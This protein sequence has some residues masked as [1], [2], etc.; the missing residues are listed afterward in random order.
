MRAEAAFTLMHA[1]TGSGIGSVAGGRW[2][3]T[4]HRA[5][6][7]G[8]M[9]VLLWGE[10]AMAGGPRY[11]AGSS[12]FDAAVAGQPVVWANGQVRYFTDPG[13]LSA[14]VN[15]SQAN[16]MV[17]QAAAVWNGVTTAAVSIQRGGSLAESVDAVL[18][19]GATAVDLPADLQPG[20]TATPVGVVFD[21]NG[22]VI[23]ALYGS[24]ASS[25]LACQSNG[26]MTVVDN[27]STSGNLLHALIIVN[28]LCGT[29]ATQIANLQYQLVR[30]FGRVLGLDWSQANEA[31]FATNR[32]TDDG[33]AGWPVMHP[34]ERLCN[35]S[36]GTCMPN[37][38][39]F[40]DGRRGGAESRVPGDG[41]EHRE[42][43]RKG[44]DG[45]GDDFCAGHGGVCAR[46]GNAG[47]KH[48]AATAGEWCAGCAVYGDGG[49]RGLF[50]GE[51]GEC[52][53][54]RDGGGALWE[55]RCESGR[56]FRFERSAAAA[57]CVQRGL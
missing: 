48:R 9:A 33:L 38:L 23:D 39:Q 27:F 42:L 31:M 12:F 7:A 57:W 45:V 19:A 15:N 24:G 43:F 52:H 51:R 28:G 5:W 40:A 16:A 54:R 8:A 49:E 11:V 50:S 30:G 1:M 46:T 13:D 53:C 26:V 34:M 44:T 18:P 17:A 2:T 35:A 25:P 22:S 10:A 14:Q 36:G 6:L 37:G 41:G 29:N 56:I 55:R 21:G 20:A 32:I 47:S 4:R 3:G